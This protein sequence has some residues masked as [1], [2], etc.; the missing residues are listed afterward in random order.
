MNDPPK[1]SELNNDVAPGVATF[2]NELGMKL[3]DETVWLN[4][5]HQL[6]GASDTKDRFL[7]VLRTWWIT[8]SKQNRTW[9][10]I[11]E[12]LKSNGMKQ[13]RVAYDISTKYNL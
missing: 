10:C 3:L 8:T 4:M 7:N 12:A 1:I 5:N 6:S 9:E 2:Y 13:I 11:V